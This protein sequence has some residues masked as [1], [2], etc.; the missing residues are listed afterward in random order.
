MMVQEA[1]LT[2]QSH[3]LIVLV[4]DVIIDPLDFAHRVHWLA[5]EFSRD[6]LYLALT[7]RDQDHLALDRML[8]TLKA[9][10]ADSL[11]RVESAIV[12]D[13][14]WVEAVRGLYNPG[15]LVICHENQTVKMPHS[16]TISL[17]DYLRT[18]DKM[19]VDAL[20]GFYQP[21]PAP[22]RGW[23]RGLV[24]WLGCLAILGGFS[25][26]ELVSTGTVSSPQH[27]ILLIVLLLF[28]FGLLTEWTRITN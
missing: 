9:V 1:V 24:F 2:K 12:E 8:A 26:L 4:P 13:A 21:A 10:T 25:Y 7:R 15:D 20:H 19:P 14:D 3:R 22:A 27:K 16:E 28:E 5:M 18:Y 6:V 11:C 17:E 23:A